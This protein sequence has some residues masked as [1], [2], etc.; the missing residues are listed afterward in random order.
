MRTSAI[1]S[2]IAAVF[3]LTGCEQ[4][5]TE[6]EVDERTPEKPGREEFRTLEDIR[7]SGKLVVLTRNAPTTWYL[8]EAGNMTGPEFE[9]VEAF[10]DYLGVKADY[11]VVY[12]IRDI[13]NG[14]ENGEADLAAASITATREREKRFLFGPSYQEVTQQ[15]VCRRDNVQPESVEELI[16]LEIMV[17]PDSS[18][19]ERLT[20]L[21]IDY[22]GL[23]WKE[24]ES[25]NTEQLLGEVWK[26]NI[27]CTVADSTI[28]D[29]NRRY[30]PE[31]IAPFNLTRDQEIAWVMHSG[32]EKLAGEIEKWLEY[33]RESGKLEQLD[34]K[35]FGFFEIFDYVDIRTYI[36]RIDERF[37]KYRAYFRIAAEKH[38]LPYT[39]VAAQGYQESHWVA[40]AVSPTGVRGIMMLTKAT[41]REMGVENRLDPKQ[42]I[43][44]GTKYLARLRK[45]FDRDKVTEPDLTWLAL[46]AY[47]I[48]RGHVHDA[49]TLA[50]RMNKNPYLW[51]DIKKVLPLLRKKQYY[52]K[53]KYGYAR[54]TEPVRYVQ[55]IREY[56]HVL[57]NEIN[58]NR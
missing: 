32:Q 58:D 5:S 47:N 3:I 2:F 52:R 27:D 18:Y 24:T 46:A 40:H 45:R 21:K 13:L 7:S 20:E 39:L 28:V 57:Q 38:D 11:K 33:F 41:A 26:R 15:V 37:P 54:G 25:M 56:E 31:L 35:Y 55:R 23:S 19:S 16:G 50:R 44:G 4:E 9:R 36:R 14:I 8:D 30:Y 48:G 49:Q 34:E 10:A 29:I 12:T 1:L 17:I 6:T 42:S 51:S 53:L 43:M 22:P